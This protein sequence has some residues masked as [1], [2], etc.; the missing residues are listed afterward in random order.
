MVLDFKEKVKARKRRHRRVRK[1][2]FGASERPRLSVFRSNKHIYAQLIDDT[3]GR[4]LTAASSLDPEYP[5]ENRHGSNREAAATVGKAIAKRI[6]ALNLKEVVFD[7]NGYLYHGRVKA[8]AD[9]ARE[10]G[11]IF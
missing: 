5:R 1:K 3:T 9:S 7:R 6:L 4:I 11:L 8:L 2:V 10:A